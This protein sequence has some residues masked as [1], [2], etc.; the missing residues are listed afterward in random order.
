MPTVQAVLQVE[1][2]LLYVPPGLT[3]RKTCNARVT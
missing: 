3:I 1:E 2:W